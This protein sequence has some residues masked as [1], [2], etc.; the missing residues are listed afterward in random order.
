MDT[1]MN[2]PEPALHRIHPIDI[3]N[4]EHEILPTEDPALSY[5]VTQSIAKVR[6]GLQKNG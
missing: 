3:K 1:L 6:D 4:V 2:N 5:A